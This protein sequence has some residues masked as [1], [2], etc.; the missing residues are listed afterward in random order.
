MGYE[1]IMLNVGTKEYLTLGKRGAVWSNKLWEIWEFINDTDA[2]KI[3]I[4]RDD[5]ELCNKILSDKTY[6][7]YDAFV[8]IDCLEITLHQLL[9]GV[10]QL[11]REIE[12]RKNLEHFSKRKAKAVTQGLEEKSKEGS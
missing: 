6:S 5:N 2:E 8:D 12:K 3:Q 1:Y 11:S 10:F 7:E 4:I 9:S